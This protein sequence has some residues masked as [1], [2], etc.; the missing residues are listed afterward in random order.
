VVIWV[1]V[2]GLFGRSEPLRYPELEVGQRADLRLCLSL[3]RFA[4]QD[5]N[6]F[7]AWN[8][9][10]SFDPSNG[11]KPWKNLQIKTH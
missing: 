2:P 8:T 4:S 3:G 9:S 1:A 10:V 5:V 7:V 6:A 11:R